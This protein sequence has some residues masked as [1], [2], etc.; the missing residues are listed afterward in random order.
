MKSF[1]IAG[2][3]CLLFSSVT[4]C[5]GI[6]RGKVTDE[7]GETVIGAS[8]V[9]KSDR[10]IGTVTDIDGNYSLSVDNQVPPIII[11]ISFIGY[12]TKEVTIDFKGKKVAI[13]N[14]RIAPEA[15]DIEE[16][17]IEGKADRSNDNYMS[18]IKAKSAVS[19]DYI[20]AETMRATGDANV[21][22]AVARVSGVATNGGFITVRG[23]GDRYIKTTLNGSRIPTLDPLTN[24]IKLDLFPAS[25][26]DNIVITKTASP[27]LPGD[28]SGAYISIETKDYPEDL[29]I[30]VNTSVGYNTQS[31]FKDIITS[32]GSKT[33]WLGFDNGFRNYDHSIYSRDVIT[34]PAIYEQFTNLGLKPYYDSLGVTSIPEG[35]KQD[36]FYKLGLVELGFL[37]PTEFSDISAINRAI[38]EYNQSD[39]K[40]Q[41]LKKINEDAV[42][43]NQQFPN[44]WEVRKRTGPLNFS[45]SFSIGNQIQLAKQPLG[46]LFGF[47]YNHNVRYDDSSTWNR[48]TVKSVAIDEA[49]QQ[50]YMQE[51]HGWSALANIAY[52]IT[53]NHS[54]SFLFM[55]NVRGVNKVRDAGYLISNFDGDNSA[56][57]DSIIGTTARGQFYEQRQQLVYQF[58]SEHYFPKPK[59]KVEWNTSYTDASSSIPDFK[60]LIAFRDGTSDDFVLD[61][62]SNNTR[63]NF[64]NLDEQLLNTRLSIEMPITKS[65]VYA[66]KIKI[67][68]SYEYKDRDFQQW[69][70]AFIPARVDLG[71]IED[72]DIKQYFDPINFGFTSNN[73]I[74]RYY[75][76]NVEPRNHIIGNSSILSAF[77]M[78]DY[79]I[80]TSLRVSGGI[81]FEQADLYTDPFLYDSLNIPL[82]DKRRLNGRVIINPGILDEFS[83]LPSI[84]LIYK[85]FQNGNVPTN[86]RLNYSRTVA[87]PSIREYSGAF[88]YDFE[89]NAFVAGNENL[90]IVDIDNFD[91]RV[92]TSFKS[93]DDLSLS[94]FY[95]NFQNHIEL[96]NSISIGVSW[97][98]VGKT[99]VQGIE[100][101]GRKKLNKNFSFR[102]NLT[103]V[104]SESEV[105]L[106]NIFDD[107]SGTRIFE[108]EDTVIRPMF[109]Q[110]P[111]IING[112]LEYES[113]KLDLSASASYNVQGPRLVI[114]TST[115]PPAIYE[116]PRHLVNLKMTKSIGEHFSVGLTVRDLLNSPIRRSYDHRSKGGWLIDFDSFRFGTSYNLSISYKL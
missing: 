64:R 3:L 50:Q 76:Q 30:Q 54:V 72:N 103:F 51:T 111:F 19:L 32:D 66:R 36:V 69:D 101:E 71:L 116:L 55:P 107:P 114:A 52:K 6:I 14:V 61:G 97:N 10:S 115:G 31:S 83:I 23:I 22:S 49:V 95:K 80:L 41:A 78:I 106:L 91:F 67:G 98:N 12:R 47:R 73:T 24:N 74:E 60:T 46:Y 45:Q 28:F 93:G 33:D 92:E 38:D 62:T 102:S 16:V 87:R 17:V 109:G 112:I 77:G 58:K 40:S 4:F 65:T 75:E 113:K 29:E 85:L 53:P 37:A 105:V 20:S 25:L 81:R 13:K 68:S 90:K 48:T 26:V 18:K 11:Q 84:N 82:N 44:N 27:D 5:Q 79:E 88:V 42:R 70:Y 15:I 104:K 110:A 108:P 43:A 9:L 21:A 86:L 63:R 94:F 89:L 34:N 100:I 96:L 57:I 1:L 59:I 2:F 7:N 99:F 39:L 8:V 35:N 56:L